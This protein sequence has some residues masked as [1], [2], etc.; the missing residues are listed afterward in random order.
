[1]MR[2]L[3]P[4]RHAPPRQRTCLPTAQHG[5]TLTELFAVVAIAGIMAAVALPNLQEFMLNSSRTTR[6][7]SLVAAMN[8]AR[9]EAISRRE[10]VT[11][12]RVALPVTTCAAGGNWESGWAI[13]WDR[14]DGT[15]PLPD[16]LVP[17][18]DISDPEDLVRVF[19]PTI[20]A[21]GSLTASTNAAGTAIVS[22][23]AYG[24][25]GR[26][27]NP[28]NNPVRFVLCDKRGAPEAR[29]MV[30]SFSGQPRISRDSNDDGTHDVSNVNVQCP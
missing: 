17:D 20:P 22:Q 6:I 1:M 16:P 12:C 3:H 9:N 7:N 19:D 27:L 15:V 21:T 26:V 29:A 2:D 8:L 30:L 5:F 28:S 14:G 10:T 24:P 23:I 11:V 13:R 18:G 4:S 25:T